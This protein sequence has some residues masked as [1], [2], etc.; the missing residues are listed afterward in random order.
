MAEISDQ[1]AMEQS[2]QPS[3][4]LASKPIGSRAPKLQADSK[5]KYVERESKTDISIFCQAQGY[6]V[7]T[8]R[9]L[10]TTS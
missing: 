5:V 6:P 3:Y 1:F 9:Y 8:F 7:P 2:Y 10:S 4:V